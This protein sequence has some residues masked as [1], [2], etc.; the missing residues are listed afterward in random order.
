MRTSTTTDWLGRVWPATDCGTS[1][2]PEV[3]YV[4]SDAS[5]V[6][7]TYNPKVYTQDTLAKRPHC[8]WCGQRMPFD[9][10]DCPFCGGYQDE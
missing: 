2:A 7:Y 5:G 8:V 4:T 6:L 10:Y 1:D 9:T 3:A